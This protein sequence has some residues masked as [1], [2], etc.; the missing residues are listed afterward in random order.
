[1]FNNKS[2]RKLSDAIREYRIKRKLRKDS[3]NRFKMIPDKKKSHKWIIAPVVF[4][5]L[6]VLIVYTLYDNGRIVVDYVTVTHSQVPVSFDGYKI[7]QISDI[8]G[9]KFGVENK[10]LVEVINSLEYDMI[11]LTGDY[12]SSPESGDYWDIIDLLD[13]LDKKDIPVLYILG[14]SDYT[15]TKTSN[16]SENW[17]MCIYPKEKNKMME[18]FEDIGVK[19]VYPISTVEKNGYFFYRN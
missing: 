9:R 14:E 8:H 2:S 4:V 13:D 6:F 16:L 15:P 12:M 18:Y 5:L 11:L 3:K 17:N 7:L 1:M 19:F 10:N